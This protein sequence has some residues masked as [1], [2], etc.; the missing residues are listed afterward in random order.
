MHPIAR[1]L[2]ENFRYSHAGFELAVDDLSR[3]QLLGYGRDIVEAIQYAHSCGTGDVPAGAI[4]VG[5][6]SR[7]P[8]PFGTVPLPADDLSADGF[9][10]RDARFHGRLA[11]LIA[12][13][14]APWHGLEFPWLT[15]SASSAGQ[16][17][18]A[19][20]RACSKYQRYYLFYYIPYFLN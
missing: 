14:E 1:G 10:D 12:T 20:K 9:P 17:N 18:S 13:G 2:F 19:S 7:A 16:P 8:D 11:A 3:E 4:A 6:G 15:T 5:A